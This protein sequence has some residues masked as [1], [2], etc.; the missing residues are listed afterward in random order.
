ML[1]IFKLDIERYLL[2]RG[3]PMLPKYEKEWLETVP[4]SGDTFVDVSLCSE[5]AS[6]F[7][8]TKPGEPETI[9]YVGTARHG[10]VYRWLPKEEWIYG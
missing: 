2:E 7:K 4:R 8:P 9:A 6:R 10:H 3:I 5:P 1:P